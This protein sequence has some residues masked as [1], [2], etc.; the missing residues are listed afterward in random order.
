MR[1]EVFGP[2]GLHVVT[3]AWISNEVGERYAIAS[4]L[5]PAG[6]GFLLD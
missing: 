6:S 4:E 3:I 2:G 5:G 1:F